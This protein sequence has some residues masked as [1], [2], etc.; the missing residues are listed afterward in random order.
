[1]LCVLAADGV[2]LWANDAELELLEYRPDEY[3][4]QSIFKVHLLPS[5][6]KMFSSKYSSL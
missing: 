4:G 5:R 1:M 2:I 3:I 6:S